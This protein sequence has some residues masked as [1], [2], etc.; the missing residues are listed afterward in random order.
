MRLQLGLLGGLYIGTADGGELPMTRKNRLVLAALALAGPTGLARSMVAHLLW[1]S[2]AQEQA[3]ASLRQALS[4]VR[5]SLGPLA[6]TV[7]AEDEQLRLDRSTTEIDVEIFSNLL[8]STSAADRQAAL[9]LYNGDLLAGIP[10]KEDALE[11]WVRPLRERL[12]ARA[13]D[14][15]VG[16]LEA[17]QDADRSRQLADQL[18]TLDPL[19]EAAHRKLMAVYAE[20]GRMNDAARQFVI[21]R[22]MLQKELGVAPSAETLRVYEMLRSASPPV[23][24]VPAATS[25]PPPEPSPFWRQKPIVAV[26][27]FDDLT[28][29]PGRS[30]LAKALTLDT[31][32]ALSRHR[33]LSVSSGNAM[34]EPELFATITG[35]RSTTDRPDYVLAGDV[36]ASDADL[37]ITVRLADGRSGALVWSESM[38]VAASRALEIP[39][40]VVQMIAARIEPQIGA[41]ERQQV[42]WRRP[43][44]PSAWDNFHLGVAS[45]YR[46]TAQANEEATVN[47]DRCTSLDP[48][49]AEAHAWRAFAA[50]ISMV[51]YDGEPTAANLDRA[52]EFAQ[53]A[54]ELDEMSAFCHFAHA[55][56]Q[57]ARRDYDRAFWSLEMAIDLNPNMATAYCALGD[58]LAYQGRLD[59]AVE[60]FAKAIHLSPRD[61]MRWAYSGYY[62]LAYL[63]KRDFEGTIRW[64][65]DATRFTHCLYWPYAHKAAALAHLGRIE[66]ARLTVA[67]LLRHRPGFSLTFARTKLFFLERQEQIELY[68]SGL[69]KAGVPEI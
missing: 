66:E 30:H 51:Y 27:P 41:R 44:N 22:D 18:L 5:K 63:F 9:V 50:I 57:L 38:N 40:E 42:L 7:I 65:D 8:A 45:F 62:S 19:N 25:Q 3:Q 68:L 58:S 14:T 55:R 4:A 26:L 33:W 10:L 2:F 1:G 47:F 23:R 6:G 28:Q 34:A 11:D 32:G 52:L 53:R 35:G 13:I 64:S 59:E 48:A 31:L 67:S 36:R 29:N 54:V 24:S 20:Q 17:Q 37:R 21:C 43:S 69:D 16:L 60:Q 39:Q 12:R 56:V 15:L 46:F 61:P 49:F